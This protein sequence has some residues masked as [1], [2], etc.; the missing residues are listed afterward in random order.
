LY[1]RFIENFSK[2]AS[3]LTNLLWK[4]ARFYFDESCF[5][6]FTL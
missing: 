4:G 3:P 6:A 5:T 1:E 2:V